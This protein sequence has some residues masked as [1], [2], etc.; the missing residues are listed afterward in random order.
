MHVP[1]QTLAES[2][3]ADLNKSFGENTAYTAQTMPRRGGI[4]SGSLALDYAIGPI[5]GFPRDRVMEIFGPESS[6]KTTLALMAIGNFLDAQPARGALILDTEHK[7]TEERLRMLLTDEHIKR[8]VVT[9]PDHVEQAQ[10]IYTKLVPTGDIA[11][12]LLDSI[13]GSPNKTMVARD[14]EDADYGNAKAVT[15]FGKIATGHSHKYECCTIGINQLRDNL[16]PND[17]SLITPGGKGWKF[18]CMLRIYVRPGKGKFSIQVGNDTVTA[19]YTV[20]GR[21]YKNHLGG[22]E[23]REFSY[24]FY[25]TPTGTKRIGV[26]QGEEVTRLSTALGVVTR[27]GGWY[28]H[29]AFPGGKVNGLPRLIALVDEDAA[30]RKVISEQ[31]YARLRDP[32]AEDAIAANDV[33]TIEELRETIENPLTRGNILHRG[34]A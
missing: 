8:L 25:N 20:A 7:L 13:G 4:S 3:V 29:D 21:I 2:L 15:R 9:Y 18:N 16:N 30:L 26:D 34:D 6:G 27:Q 17:H 1:K 31:T 5:G 12:A 10:N 19:G 28:Y 32:E 33:E 14:A 24:W 22:I 11:I 23:G